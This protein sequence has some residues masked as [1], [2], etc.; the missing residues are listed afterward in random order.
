[1]N[2][3]EQLLLGGF[4]FMLLAIGH[5]SQKKQLRPIA[6][7]VGLVW[8]SL[9]ASSIVEYTQDP[10]AIVQS[11]A[12]PLRAADSAGAPAMTTD[13]V[14]A[15][16]AVQLRRTQGTWTQVVLPNAQRGWLPSRAIIAVH[17]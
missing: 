12:G 6:A 1:M 4:L 16:T 14:P 13:W 5:L 2:L 9:V 7:I 17:R 3:A 11:D 15:G 8:L 10:L